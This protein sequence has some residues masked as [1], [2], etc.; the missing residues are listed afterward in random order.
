MTIKLPVIYNN[1]I[2]IRQMNLKDTLNIFNNYN[3]EEVAW[4]YNFGPFETFLEARNWLNDTIREDLL[5]GVF[6]NDH[7][8]CHFNISGF[9][10]DKKTAT[11]N[12]FFN[13]TNSLINIKKLEDILTNVLK[14]YFNYLDLSVIKIKVPINNKLLNEVLTSLAIKIKSVKKDGYYN[15][16][17]GENINLNLYEIE[18]G[19]KL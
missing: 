4:L 18:R 19:L 12:I 17:T 5:Y 14:I 3:N 7:Y 11:L 6:E 8:I 15:R 10:K 2:I 1:E 9:N 13:E 16:F